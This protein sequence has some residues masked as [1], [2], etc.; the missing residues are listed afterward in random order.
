MLSSLYDFLS[1]FFKQKTAYEIPK[2]NWSSEVCSSDLTNFVTFDHLGA[3]KTF[4]PKDQ[5]ASFNFA[6]ASCAKTGSEN[7]VF[8]TI[9]NLRPLFFMNDGDFHYLNITS[10]ALVKFR[11]AYD[12]VLISPAQARLYRSVPFI[13]VWDD[14]AF[15]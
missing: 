12:Q 10:N 11:M 1:F 5:P 6:F 2:S 13:Y 8:N 7:P 15:R 4:P 14:H 3:F 9:R